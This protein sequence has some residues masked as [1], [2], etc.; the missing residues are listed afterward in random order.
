MSAETSIG[1]VFG[2]LIV[3]GVFIVIAGMRHRTKVLEMVHRERLAMIER[4][5]TPVGD[6]EALSAAES[7]TRRSARSNRL[8]SAGIVIV[9]LGL[10]LATLIGFTGG[11]PEIAVG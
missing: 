3:G 11:E 8:L 1:L 9:G 10:G 5:G 7:P 2:L 6:L 4:G